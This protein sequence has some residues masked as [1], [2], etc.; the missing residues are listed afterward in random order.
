[1]IDRSIRTKSRLGIVAMIAVALSTAACGGGGG[2]G[3]ASPPPPPPPPV[4]RTPQKAVFIAEDTTL[5]QRHLY[6]AGDEGSALTPLTTAF[7]NPNG[8]VRG[9]ELSPDGQTVAYYA[10][11]DIDDVMELYF[12]DVDGGTPISAQTGFPANTSFF[13]LEWSPDS[14]QLAYAANPGGN[15]SRGFGLWEVFLVNRDGSDNRKING[16]TG[17]PPRV[18]VTNPTWSPDG[19][20]V[21]QT[22]R[23]LAPFQTTIGHNVYDTT[24]GTPNSTRVTPAVDWL[25][26][27]DIDYA[28]TWSASSDRLIYMSSFES[29]SFM[30][31]YSTAVDGSG[32]VRLNGA[33]TSGGDVFSYRVSPDGS[34]IAYVADQVVDGQY[35]LFVVSATGSNLMRMSAS[36]GRGR[37]PN[38]DWSPDSTRI[39]FDDDRNIAGTREL[40][41]AT[42]GGSDVRVNQPLVDGQFAGRP[43]WSP[44]GQSL[45]FLSDQYE[46]GRFEAYAV[47][48]DGSNERQLSRMENGGGF[49]ATV[50]SPD[51]SMFAYTAT[52]ESPGVQE[53]FVASADGSTNTKLNAELAENVDIRHY[54]VVWSDDNSRVIF[55]DHL[56]DF[57]TGTREE[58]DL[59][60]G[61]TD[62]AAPIRIN[63]TFD[64]VGGHSY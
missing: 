14:S 41:I 57:R 22:V 48:A 1:M 43:L 24:L 3:G 39:A 42:L 20:Y 31:L 56:D 6:V 44:D 2:G 64:Y 21:A 7:A 60:V 46:P 12:V 53:L 26:S 45:A 59:W 47:N 55:S 37:V 17:S 18:A 32:T 52:Q 28:V 23:S 15:S 4:S 62:G 51:S 63:E 54:G 30:R 25:N 5:G 9:F 16:S 19:R 50:W 33:L 49:A 58:L 13:E 8:D 38:F 35:D 29:A 40:Y 61:T 11:A 27:E 34:Q 36:L 10:D